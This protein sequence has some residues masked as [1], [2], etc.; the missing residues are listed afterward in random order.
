VPDQSD[1]PIEA[2]QS[3]TAVD[4]V[5]SLYD[6]SDVPLHF[7]RDDIHLVGRYMAFVEGPDGETW[8]ALEKG[9]MVG[10][11]WFYHEMVECRSLLERGVDIFQRDELRQHRWRGH[12]QA[13]IA[14]HQYLFQKARAMGYNVKQIGSLILWNTTVSADDA[15]DDFD[16]AMFWDRSVR[17]DPHD[18]PIVK[19]FFEAIK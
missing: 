8:K 15:K 13:L 18:E 1:V 4:R 7:D 3:K 16:V 11:S 14:E 10:K 12:A 6:G 9:G 5:F 19:A 2:V 17:V